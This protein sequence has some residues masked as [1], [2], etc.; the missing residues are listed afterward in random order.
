MIP[1]EVLDALI[2]SGATAE[3]IVAAV[4]ADAAI[5]EQKRAEK[6]QKDAERQRR[7]RESRDVTV[8]PRDKHVTERDPPKEYIKPPVSP[9]Q[10]KACSGEVRA[11][12]QKGS[13]IST[14]WQPERPLPADVATLVAQWPPGRLERELSG[15][16]DYWLAR[17]R[18]A[19]R[20][21]WDRTWWNRIRDQHD[22]VMR[23]T[24]GRGQQSDPLRGPRPSAALDMRIRAQRELEAERN[25]PAFDSGPRLALPSFGPS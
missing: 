4:K 3:M 14:D 6:R 25:N 24:N 8:T 7:H 13:R 23:A 9:S 11:R 21:D 16:R 15:F 19:A 2:A 12:A 20:T 18:D 1:S 22:K 17:S 10:A 5:D